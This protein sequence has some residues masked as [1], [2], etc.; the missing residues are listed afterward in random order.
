MQI[1]FLFWITYLNFIFSDNSGP[2]HPGTLF[3]GDFILLISNAVFAILAHRVW[4][5]FLRTAQRNEAIY[6]RLEED[7]EDEEYDEDEEMSDEE[8]NLPDEQIKTDKRT[9]VISEFFPINSI[10]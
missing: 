8:Q 6:N 5:G 9:H 4:L 10:V 7:D 3:V 2:E 1:W